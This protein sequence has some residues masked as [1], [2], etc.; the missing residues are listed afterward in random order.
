MMKNWQYDSARACVT[1]VDNGNCRITVANVWGKTP[2]EVE[3]HGRLIAAAPELAEALRDV[4]AA[5]S[6]GGAI[7]GNP[8][9]KHSAPSRTTSRQ[10]GGTEMSQKERDIFDTLREFHARGRTFYAYV[11]GLTAEEFE[12]AGAI[13]A[14]PIL[15]QMTPEPVLKRR[16]DVEGMGLTLFCSDPVLVKPAVKKHYAKILDECEKR[17]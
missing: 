1:G 13:G 17:G 11:H 14:G 6:A 5:F 12:Q 7:L 8:M 10:T 2:E 3:A 4:S 16:V 15:L 9:P